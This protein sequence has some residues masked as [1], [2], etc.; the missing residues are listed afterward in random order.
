MVK[1]QDGNIYIT[2]YSSGNLDPA[3]CTIAG[4]DDIYLVKYNSSGVR[5]WTKMFGTVDN[6]RPHAIAYNGSDAIYLT[7]YTRGN[8][9]GN[10]N[11]NDE[12]VMFVTQFSTGGTIIWTKLY[13]LAGSKAY[14]LAWHDG[15]IYVTGMSF[16]GGIYKLFVAKYD[17][18]GVQEWI[19]YYADGAN[20]QSI[21]LDASGNIYVTVSAATVTL[22]K[23]DSSGVE[24][25]NRPRADIYAGKGIVLDGDSNLYFTGS[26]SSF[27]SYI[28]KYDTSGN[29]V[30]EQAIDSGLPDGG[31][32][33]ALDSSRNV[34]V[35]GG[36]RGNL[37]GQTNNGSGSTYDMFL[38]K[39]QS[40]GTRQWTRLLGT[41]AYDGGI[42]LAVLSDNYVLV[43][44]HTDGVLATPS[45][46]GQ[47]YFFAQYNSSGVLQ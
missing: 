32:A 38:I 17:G 36:T 13:E 37:D 16:N 28:V 29:V 27:H 30:W 40:D 3:N 39:Y 24:L 5:L 43:Y 4:G 8:L 46:G 23:F 25:W 26:T 1:D 44:G 2:G 14:A 9:D 20:G 10:V 42:G 11:T 21:A 18:V 6:D 33:V 22:Y 41:T 34:Y 15:H 45:A 35:T 47:D 19:N 31:N 12:E 7:G